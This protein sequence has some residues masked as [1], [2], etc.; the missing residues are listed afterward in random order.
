MAVYFNIR[1]KKNYEK[2]EKKLLTRLTN[3]SYYKIH[4][5]LFEYNLISKLLNCKFCF[6]RF[7][8]TVK[9]LSDK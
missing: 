4:K 5:T 8:N 7:R 6:K 2:Y 3:H 9:I 1:C